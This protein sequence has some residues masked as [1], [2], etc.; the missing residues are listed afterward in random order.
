MRIIPIMESNKYDLHREFREELKYE[1]RKQSSKEEL[2]FSEV[3]TRV[4]QNTYLKA[5]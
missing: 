1:K 2:S 5:K 3:L 4:K